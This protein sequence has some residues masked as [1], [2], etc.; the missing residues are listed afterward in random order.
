[1][2]R[3]H[4]LKRHVRLTFLTGGKVKPLKA[5]KKQQKDMDEDEVAFREKQKAGES[6]PAH[7]F[8]LCAKG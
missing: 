1:M 5:P 6:P 2:P 7:G 4:P 3:T 8:L